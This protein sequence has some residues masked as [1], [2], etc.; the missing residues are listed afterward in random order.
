M[1]EGE[2]EYSRLIEKNL[3]LAMP[4]LFD[5]I[6]HLKQTSLKLAVVSSSG[7][8]H[9]LLKLTKLGLLEFFPIIISGDQISQ[10][11]PHLEGYLKASEKLKIEP[12]HCLV[13]EDAENGVVAAK[14]A[15]MACVVIPSEYVQNGDY[16][17]ADYI[18]QNLSEVIQILI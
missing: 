1:V 8:Q 15:G 17:K 10:G 13:L 4:G 18:R 3:P 7:M 14:S 16:S 11:K 6:E 12:E 9:I 2:L 5:L